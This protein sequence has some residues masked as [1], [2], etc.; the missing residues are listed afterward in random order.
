VSRKHSPRHRQEL[1][2]CGERVVTEH[3]LHVERDEVEHREERCIEE[4]HDEVGGV[5]LSEANSAP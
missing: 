1:Q 5:Q 3:L 4:E 2:P